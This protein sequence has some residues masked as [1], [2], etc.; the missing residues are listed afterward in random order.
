[1]V[2]RDQA[3]SRE[4][5]VFQYAKRTSLI[6]FF[7]SLVNILLT[8]GIAGLAGYLIPI[9]DKP[10]VILQKDRGYLTAN[11]V[12]TFRPRT[13]VVRA[14]VERTVGSL[15]TYNPDGRDFRVFKYIMA[16]YIISAFKKNEQDALVATIKFNR[17]QIWRLSEMRRY[18]DRK[19]PAYIGLAL[20][21]EKVYFEDTEDKRGIQSVDIEVSPHFSRAYVVPTLITRGN[22]WGLRLVGV[23]PMSSETKFQKVWDASYDP[24]TTKNFS[25]SLYWRPQRSG[26]N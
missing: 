6:L 22:P 17:R 21:G 2:V 25:W 10:P 19:F 1:M 26:G 7:T 8:L 16:P 3:P 5:N 20:R 9:F 12:R 11:P 4:I 24:E 14:F 15:L 13:E 18:F 23:Q